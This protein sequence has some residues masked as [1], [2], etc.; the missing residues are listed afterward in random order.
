MCVPN[1]ESYMAISREGTQQTRRQHYE[2]RNDVLLPLL[3]PA[4]T[5]PLHLSTTTS[6]ALHG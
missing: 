6:M 5:L 4:A 1:A 3:A 2:H